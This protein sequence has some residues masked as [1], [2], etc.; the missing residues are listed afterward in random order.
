MQDRLNTARELLYHDDKLTQNG[1]E[2]LADLLIYVMS[3]PKGELTAAKKKLIEVNFLPKA[4]AAT[5][6]FVLD[7]MAKLAKEMMQP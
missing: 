7:L 1:R 2:Q 6:E 5:R 3:N 4:A